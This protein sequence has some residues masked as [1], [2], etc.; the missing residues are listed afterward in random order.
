LSS[1][2]LGVCKPG[3]EKK[4]KEKKK[5]KNNYLSTFYGNCIGLGQISI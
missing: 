1:L 4:G 5:R 3:G 2:G